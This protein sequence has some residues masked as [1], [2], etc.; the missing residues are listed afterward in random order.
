LKQRSP[1]FKLGVVASL[2]HVCCKALPLLH[3]HLLHHHGVHGLLHATVCIEIERL[4]LLVWRHLTHKGIRLTHHI[5]PELLLLLRVT[6]LGIHHI[7]V[8]HPTS[9]HESILLLLRPHIWLLIKSHIG[10]ESLKLRLLLL[11]LVQVRRYHLDRSLTNITVKCLKSIEIRL[12][13]E[14]ALS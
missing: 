10:L 14:S 11:L 12:L 8:L 3:L 5:G 13:H 6:T 7:R 2:V 9:S 4:L 1:E